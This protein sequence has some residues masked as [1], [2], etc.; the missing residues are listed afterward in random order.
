MKYLFVYMYQGKR[1]GK[2]VNGQGSIEMNVTGIDKITPSVVHDAI[3]WVKAD[4]ILKGA[5]IDA[6]APMG[7]FKYDEE[8]NI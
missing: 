2:L 1:E 4:L 7:W 5:V 8:D 6:I 3:E